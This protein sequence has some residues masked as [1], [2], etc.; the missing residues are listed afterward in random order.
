MAE[1]NCVSRAA[2]LDLSGRVVAFDFSR[3]HAAIF[4]RESFSEGTHVFNWIATL[5][6]NP[7]S[8]ATACLSPADR[9]ELDKSAGNWTAVDVTPAL[10]T[11][12]FRP[13]AAVHAWLVKYRETLV[14]LVL[15]AFFALA[16]IIWQVPT[17][18]CQPAAANRLLPTGCCCCQPF[19]VS[20]LS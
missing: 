19:F 9:P 13:L 2:P 14:T 12:P 18:C 16:G 10:W 20:S 15:M 3:Q 5:A 7:L 11:Q 8:N 1:L 4:A 17:S 6:V